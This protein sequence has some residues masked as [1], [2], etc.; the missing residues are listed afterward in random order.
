MTTGRNCERNVAVTSPMSGNWSMAPMTLDLAV[1]TCAD[2]C[3]AN[4]DA[5]GASDGGMV[6]FATTVTTVWTVRQ[7][8]WPR[9]RRLRRLPRGH[10]APQVPVSARRVSPRRAWT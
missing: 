2:C 7:A 8:N 9:E 5:A 6:A 1:T 3:G 10:D 4:A